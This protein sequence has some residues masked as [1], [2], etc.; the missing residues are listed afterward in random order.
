MYHNLRAW[1]GVIMLCDCFLLFLTKVAFG[2]FAPYMIANE[3][4][5]V[6]VNEELPSPVTM[7][8]FRPNVVVSGMKAFE[9][10][11]LS[12]NVFSRKTYEVL[13]LY[14]M[15]YFNFNSCLTG[16]SGCQD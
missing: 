1:K 6:A 4:S 12:T 10:V 11:S 7:E 3:A 15:K 16:P 5:L 9:E 8:N 2:D 13:L 14:Y